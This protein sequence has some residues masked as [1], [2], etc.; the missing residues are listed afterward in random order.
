[1]QNFRYPNSYIKKEW[2]LLLM[3]LLY[4]FGYIYR[5]LLGFG[6][7]ICFASAFAFVFTLISFNRFLK[8]QYNIKLA[9]YFLVVYST[10]SLSITLSY[11]YDGLRSILLNPALYLP[12]ITILLST[13]KFDYSILKIIQISLIASA[14][15]FLIF[16]Y[17]NFSSFIIMNGREAINMLKDQ[18]ISFDNVSKNFVPCLGLLV[19][20]SPVLK[21][22]V[23]LF[24]LIIFVINMVIAIFL[25]RR[26]IIFTNGLFLI[27]GIYCWIKYRR[28]NGVL[29]YA[30]YSILLITVGYTAFNGLDYIHSSDSALFEMLSKRIDLDSRNSVIEAYYADMNSNPLYW[31]F[32]KGIE[33]TYYCPGIEDTPF[34]HTIEAGWQH[35]V[36]KVGLIGFICYIY[37]QLKAMR[38]RNNNP[39]IMACSFYILISVI[40]LYPAGVPAFH[41][42]YVLIWICVSICLDPKFR[43]L[44]QLEIVNLL[45]Y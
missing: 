33:S 31:I 12:Y 43:S 29:K 40:E 21:K 23:V 45:S 38:F 7:V 6:M 41:L 37:I 26:N 14:I 36:L 11:S 4:S 13:R 3:P 10:L 25:G 35:I 24:V 18:L 15:L 17:M 39:L 28:V 20:L 8:L 34:R 2:I 16:A 5:S 42:R 27:S 22:K 19:L 30:L 44:K 32:G 9:L 1:M